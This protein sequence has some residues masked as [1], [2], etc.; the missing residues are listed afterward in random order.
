MRGR[1][2]GVRNLGGG[3]ALRVE[4]PELVELRY[5]LADA[6]RH[7]LLPQDPAAFDPHVTVQNKVPPR[8]AAALHG[9]LAADFL[10]WNFTV[11]GLTLWRYCGGPWEKLRD[12]RF[13]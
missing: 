8:E 13:S 6:W 11:E 2:V 1:V 7:W 5:A 9:V 10:P 12:F 3:V 4:A